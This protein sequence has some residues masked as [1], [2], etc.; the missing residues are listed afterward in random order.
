MSQYRSPNYEFKLS[1]NSR[2]EKKKYTADDD[3][4]LM[5]QLYAIGMDNENVYNEIRDSIR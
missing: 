4:F 1:Y 3:K 5:C 2:K